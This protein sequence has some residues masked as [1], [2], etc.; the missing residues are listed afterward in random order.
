MMLEDRRRD[1]VG[2]RNTNKGLGKA[3]GI[4]NKGT[5]LLK[6][7]WDKWDEKIRCMCQV[8]HVFFGSFNSVS[9]AIDTYVVIQVIKVSELHDTFRR[10]IHQV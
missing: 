9:Y 4:D 8:K 2:T 3:T 1:V 6:I 7:L 10:G 5:R